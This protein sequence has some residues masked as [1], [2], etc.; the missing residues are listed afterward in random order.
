MLYRFICVVTFEFRNS[1]KSKDIV[2]AFKG[3]VDCPDF[4]SPIRGQLFILL[5]GVR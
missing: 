2:I 3:F 4:S 5:G 1:I